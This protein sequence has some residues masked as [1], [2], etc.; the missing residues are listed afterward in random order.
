MDPE[1]K[2]DTEQKPERPLPNYDSRWDPDPAYRDPW[3]EPSY[4]S[5]PEFRDRLFTPG[6]TSRV[7]FAR[8]RPHKPGDPEQMSAG[9]VVLMLLLLVLFALAIGSAVGYAAVSRASTRTRLP[10][11]ASS[12]AP[13]AMEAMAPAV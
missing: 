5:A 2:N 3:Q 1:E 6:L 12:R 7:D 9:G 13:K 11:M 4:R 8:T 10:S